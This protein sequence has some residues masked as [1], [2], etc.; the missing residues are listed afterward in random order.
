M[1]F[2]KVDFDD[3]RGCLRTLCNLLHPDGLCC[4]RCGRRDHQ[5]VHR[6]HRCNVILDYRCALC[7]RVFNVWTKTPFQRTKRGPKQI[8]RILAAERQ[9]IPRAQMARDL[10]CD[11]SALARACQKWRCWA[12]ETFGPP[13]R[14]GCHLQITSQTTQPSGPGKRERLAFV[15]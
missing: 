10:N 13:A 5:H 3:Q 7:G 14:N 9:G 4:P 15:S 8:L 1:E 6:H 2:P 12:L 11:R